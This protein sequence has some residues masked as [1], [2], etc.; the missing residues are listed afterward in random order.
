M[1]Q[2]CLIIAAATFSHLDA[3][4]GENWRETFVHNAT[5][6]STQ[7]NLL[8]R[9][10][11]MT[12]L[13]ATVFSVPRAALLVVTANLQAQAANQRA[14][15]GESFYDQVWSVMIQT[16]RGDCPAAA[17]AGVRISAGRV[18]PKD[19]GCSIEGHVAPNGAL[20]VNVRPAAGG[21]V[22]RSPNVGRKLW[23]RPFIG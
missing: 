12:S 17:R 5:N 21:F 11:P 1:R 23:R 16:T 8:R 19:A 6:W 7:L 4:F 20:R 14:H 3:A 15:G 9:S 10:E 18:P 22:H 2:N 13:L